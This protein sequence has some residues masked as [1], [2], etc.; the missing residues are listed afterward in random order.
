MREKY[1]IDLSALLSCSGSVEYTHTRTQ[2]RRKKRERWCLQKAQGDKEDQSE[3]PPRKGGRGRRNQKEKRIWRG[4]GMNMARVDDKES[5]DAVRER[6][7]LNARR[8]ETERT[9]IRE[10]EYDQIC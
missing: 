7:G 4:R 6:E 9:K 3:E 5:V 10:N 2:P 1:C 8:E